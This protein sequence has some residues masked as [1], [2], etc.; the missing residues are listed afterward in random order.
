MLP[1]EGCGAAG[2]QVGEAGHR[3]QR[4][5]PAPEGGPH[6]GH[7]RGGPQGGQSGGAQ[8]Q[9]QGEGLGAAGSHPAVV[10]G[11]QQALPRRQSVGGVHGAIHVQAPGEQQASGE[12]QGHLG[13]QGNAALEAPPQQPLQQ[14]QHGSHPGRKAGNACKARL[15]PGPG[16]QHRIED[17]GPGQI[18]QPGGGAGGFGFRRTGHGAIV[19]WWMES[20]VVG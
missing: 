11:L 19:A 1:V 9:Q 2:P 6:Q 18:P 7:R 17:P 14:P 20:R 4:R 5:H 8:Q 3:Q 12:H 16:G 10:H 13:E 15:R